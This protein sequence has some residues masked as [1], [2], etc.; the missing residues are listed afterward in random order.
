ML[1]SITVNDSI[2]EMKYWGNAFGEPAVLVVTL[3]NKKNIFIHSAVRVW[4]DFS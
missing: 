4:L 3:V 1:I 2:P